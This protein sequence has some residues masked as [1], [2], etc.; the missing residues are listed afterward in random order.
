MHST[1]YPDETES[2]IIEFLIDSAR[3]G[4]AQDVLDIE[5]VLDD[6][7]SF[8]NCTNDQGHS[9]LHYAAANGHITVLKLLLSEKYK[10]Q[11]DLNTKNNEGNTPLHWAATNNHL[12]VI[13][14]LIEAGCD[15]NIQNATG[16]TP[17]A[18][19]QDRGFD[20]LELLLLEQ[21]KGLEEFMKQ[22]EENAAQGDDGEC[23][24]ES[25]LSD[26]SS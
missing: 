8:I 7:V 19:I 3:S 16:N 5:Q 24:D 26:D 6:N 10:A 2:D 23:S 15:C 22:C 21:D 13:T 17:L 4:E 14:L 11:L 20:E 18:E 25:E 1:I 9:M 12:N